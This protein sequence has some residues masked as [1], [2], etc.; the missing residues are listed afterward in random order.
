MNRF[1]PCTGLSFIVDNP[2]T[3]I[4]FRPWGGIRFV[5]HRP[6]GVTEG[7]ILRGYSMPN[8]ETVRRLNDAARGEPEHKLITSGIR[9]L[10]GRKM[11]PI[12]TAVLYDDPD[13]DRSFGIVQVDGKDYVW[14]IECYQPGTNETEHVL[15]RIQGQRTNPKDACYHPLDKALQG[16][17]ADPK[18]VRVLSIMTAAEYDAATRAP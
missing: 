11:L 4:R 3:N 2:D 10:N 12:L 18:V 6:S 14:V 16:D 13:D 1:C 5:R 17:P 7:P 8:I 9:A 15:A